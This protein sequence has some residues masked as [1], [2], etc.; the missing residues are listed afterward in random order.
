MGEK[1]EAAPCWGAEVLLE[2]AEAAGGVSD[3]GRDC[4]GV[5]GTQGLA[6]NLGH[7]LMTP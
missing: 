4:P 3:V 2:Q 7:R 5:A 1:R 6:L